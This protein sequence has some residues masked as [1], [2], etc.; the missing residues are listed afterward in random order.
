MLDGVAEALSS[1][2]DEDE[3]LV[4][5]YADALPRQL[6]ELC[7]RAGE[8]AVNVGI[9]EATLVSVAGGLSACGMRP[10][11]IA[12]ASFLASRAHAQLRQDVALAG[13]PV[14]LVGFAAGATLAAMGPTHCTLDDLALIG[15]LPGV[16]LAV[17]N[18]ARSATALLR[19][20]LAGERCGYLRVEACEQSL[21]APVAA[22]ERYRDGSDATVIACGAATHRAIE[23][24]DAARQAGIDAGVLSVLQLRPLDLAAL[25]VAFDAGPV[26]I[27]EDHLAAGGLGAL[28]L[29]AMPEARSLRFAHLTPTAYPKGLTTS[30]N[31]EQFAVSG[32]RILNTLL[33]LTDH[34][35]LA[36]T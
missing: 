6:E 15:L 12:L 18:D 3:R 30:L 32:E 22:V 26:I 33:E 1:M 9:A 29:E 24:A 27:V 34:D 28:L 5:L 20:M 23:A 10:V 21:H 7:D 25:R 2:L 31:P 16:E 13:V 35:D 17:A 36:R 14:T 8:R 11:V 4:L 19:Q